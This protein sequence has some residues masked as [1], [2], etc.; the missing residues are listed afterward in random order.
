LKNLVA[1]NA[2][3][4]ISQATL[5][6]MSGNV[7]MI[8]KKG[9]TDNPNHTVEY[10]HEAVLKETDRIFVQFDNATVGDTLYMFA[11]GVKRR[12]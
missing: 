10:H 3:S 9:S 12:V 2:G 11:N 5:G 1:Y 7:F 8:L 6:Y 4:G